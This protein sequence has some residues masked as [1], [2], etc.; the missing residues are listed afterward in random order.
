MYQSA[1]L[2]MALILLLEANDALKHQLLHIGKLA[3]IKFSGW[4]NFKVGQVLEHTFPAGLNSK[5][6]VAMLGL[7]W[8]SSHTNL[9]SRKHVV[10]AVTQVENK[11]NDCRC[12]IFLFY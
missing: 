1:R 6:D 11:A 10:F 4:Q 3:W 9:V 2:H 8:L 5:K 7:H 12:P